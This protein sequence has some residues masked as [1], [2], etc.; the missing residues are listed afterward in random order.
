[1]TSFIRK[2][3]ASDDKY[4]RGVLGFITSSEAYP[5]AALLGITAAMRTGVG[6]VRY[7]GPSQVS[8]LVLQ[9]RP[10]IVLQDGRAQAWVVGSGV[11]VDD[12]EQAARINRVVSEKNLVVVDAGA[13]QI[14]D[15]EN[16]IATCVL[17]PH[18]G[19]AA[20]LLDS[21]G[22]TIARAE[23]EADPIAAA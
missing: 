23:I 19:E 9:V 6:L 15:F 12:Q 13:L 16:C 18:A 8:D 10:E 11:P 5:G 17:T 14:I 3:N 1:M 2:P 7:L 22:K 21:L 20:A 4:S